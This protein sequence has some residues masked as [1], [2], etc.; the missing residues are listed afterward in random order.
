MSAYEGH[1]E[2]GLT[3][4]GRK[5]RGVLRTATSRGCHRRIR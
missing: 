5:R 2:A 4:R 1:A 3:L